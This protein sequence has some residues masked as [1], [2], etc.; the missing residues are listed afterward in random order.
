MTKNYCWVNKNKIYAEIYDELLEEELSMFNR[1]HNDKIKDYLT[2]KIVNENNFII[3]ENFDSVDDVISDLVIKI[4]DTALTNNLQGNTVLMFAGPGEM[5]E[6]FHM[7]NLLMKMSDSELN[8]FASI[9]NIHM[10]P[11]YWGCGIFKTTYFTG[12]AKSSIITKKDV[13][14]IFI[15]NYYHIGVM[16]NT[17]GNMIQ[18]EFTGEDPFKVIGTNFIQD[19]VTNVIGFGLIPYIESSNEYNE[20]AS[21]ILGRQINGRV[22]LSLLCPVTNKKFWNIDIKTINNILK[23]MSNNDLFN[24]IEKNSNDLDKKDINPF[25]ILEMTLLNSIK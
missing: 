12:K 25:Y 8:E 24:I 16:I 11:I 19:N 2:K 21:E 18:I 7:E 23:V 17:D 9:S 1:D 6:I 3:S 15:Q 5:Y 13:A 10:S 22:F 4:T 14:N 20:K